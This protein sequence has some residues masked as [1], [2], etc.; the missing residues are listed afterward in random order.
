MTLFGFHEFLLFFLSSHDSNLS[1]QQEARHARGPHH[2]IGNPSLHP[3]LSLCHW[4]RC[5]SALGPH[6]SLVVPMSQV[7][8]KKTPPGRTGALSPFLAAATVRRHPQP[9]LNS[10][11][12][13][14]L[15]GPLAAK[16]GLDTRQVHQQPA[17]ITD[18]S[19]PQPA[20]GTWINSRSYSKTKKKSNGKYAPNV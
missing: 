6:L 11:S 3:Q 7:T 4:P 1:K 14:S 5:V 18:S 12:N 16:P 19:R 15:G 20:L 10:Q 13:T 17:G 2:H 9:W 8:P